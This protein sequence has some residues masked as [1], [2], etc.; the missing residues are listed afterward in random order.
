MTEILNKLEELE[1]ERQ[2]LKERFLEV[3]AVLEEKKKSGENFEKEAKEYNELFDKLMEIGEK[4]NKLKKEQEE[5]K[6]LETVKNLEEKT[7][8]VLEL[9]RKLSQL[10][11]MIKEYEEE[12]ENLE[13]IVLSKIKYIAE[14]NKKLYTKRGMN[15]YYV[16][17]DRVIKEKICKDIGIEFPDL[18]REAV[19]YFLEKKYN[20]YIIEDLIER[21]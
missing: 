9:D 14:K 16:K 13:R 11:K 12:R 1:Q 19:E 5:S 8:K 17:L 6:A 2:R 10:Y 4:I 20:I 15:A 3:K 21:P 7:N 18:I